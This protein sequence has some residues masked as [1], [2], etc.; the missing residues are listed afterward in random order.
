MADCAVDPTRVFVAGM[1]AGGA[2]AAVMADR[3]PEMYAA[4]GIHSGLAHGTAQDVMSAFGAMQGGGLPGTRE[5]RPGHCFS[6]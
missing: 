2:M 5:H 6:R 3:Y 1:S 4:V